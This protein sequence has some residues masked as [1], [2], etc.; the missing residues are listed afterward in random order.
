MTTRAQE[1]EAEDMGFVRIKCRV[2]KY[3]GWSDDNGH[4]PRCLPPNMYWDETFEEWTDYRP[5]DK[6]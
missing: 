3:R 4:C 2:C 5:E 1:Q 6:A